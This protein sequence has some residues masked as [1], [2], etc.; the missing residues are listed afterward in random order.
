M[1]AAAPGPPFLLV[2]IV[3]YG[4]TDRPIQIVAKY[5]PSVGEMSL[6]IESRN[7]QSRVGH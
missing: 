1:R 6:S 5:V 7:Q 2:R 3:P 4:I